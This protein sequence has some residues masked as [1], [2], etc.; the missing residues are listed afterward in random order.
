MPLFVNVAAVANVPPMFTVS[1]R[2]ALQMDAA[3]NVTVC[4]LATVNP[5]VPLTVKAFVRVKLLPV[6][7]VPVPS[8]FKLPILEDELFVIVEATV[9]VY[10]IPTSADTFPHV[11][12]PIN[13]DAVIDVVA[14]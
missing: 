7:K 3:F 12:G 13:I 11:Y 1:V 5:P 8:A 9:P 4:P 2:L 14:L 10:R 6:V